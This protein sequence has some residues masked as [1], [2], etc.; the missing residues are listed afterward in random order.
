MN[1]EMEIDFFKASY[2]DIEEI[3]FSVRERKS[4][5]SFLNAENDTKEIF[6]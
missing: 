3:I 6:S 5:P 4:N 2:K 1:L